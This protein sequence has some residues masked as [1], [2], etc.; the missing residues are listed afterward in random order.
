VR[1]LSDRTSGESPERG[2]DQPV[3]FQH[4]TRDRDRAVVVLHAH[5]G[6]DVA[7]DDRA[8]VGRV[9]A[10]CDAVDVPRLIDALDAQVFGRVAG[11]EVVVASDELDGES[12]VSLA[13][14]LE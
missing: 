4:K 10:Q 7:G 8:G 13:P 11:V 6:V 12:C 5:G 1:K 2:H 3:A 14:S 9:M